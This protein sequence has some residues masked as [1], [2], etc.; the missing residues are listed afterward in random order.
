MLSLRGRKVLLFGLALMAC[1]RPGTMRAGTAHD[2]R[3]GPTTK[4]GGG[5]SP[6]ASA[7]LRHGHCCRSIHPDYVRPG[8]GPARCGSLCQPP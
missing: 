7:A 2:G 5:L 4:L 3:C 6:A 1:R 8:P